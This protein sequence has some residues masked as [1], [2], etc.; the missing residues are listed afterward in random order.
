MNMNRYI[1][2]LTFAFFGAMALFACDDK[3]SAVVPTAPAE[4]VYTNS[5]EYG[6]ESFDV[7]SVVRYETE[8]T[9][10]LWLSPVQ[11]LKT[12]G[13][14]MEKGN[15]GVISANRTYLGGRDL[16]K[17]AGSYAGFNDFRFDN[18]YN[19]KAFID[20][21]FKD[22]E[23]SLNFKVEKLF[24][25]AGVSDKFFSGNY[26][27]E[28]IDHEQILKNQW[29]FNRIVKDIK[30]AKLFVKTDSEYNTTTKFT[31]YDDDETVHEAVSVTIPEAKLDEEI[32]DIADILALTYDSGKAFELVNS[33][34]INKMLATLSDDNLEID[35][36]FANGSNFLAA[37]YTGK[38]EISE[39]KPNHISCAIYEKNENGEFEFLTIRRTPIHKLF[40][41]A[42]YS[43]TSFYFGMSEDAS[44]QYNH[45]Y[46]TLFVGTELIDG[47]YRFG[48]SA[49]GRFK[50]SDDFNTI[51]E[52]PFGGDEIPQ[53]TMNIM[54][55]SQNT[56]KIILRLD[57]LIISNVKMAQVEV[58]YEGTGLFN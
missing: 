1:K 28:F 18:G 19:G 12:I 5:Y 15:Y 51:S 8:T 34:N 50:Y 57:N 24:S 46:P 32:N 33:A 29:S 48:A 3:P 31:F 17:K 52:Q 35:M 41:K 37:D 36:D 58:F 20:M 54:Q 40:V 43:S 4:M 44:S 7:Q 21:S 10:E 14:V 23:V 13:E 45:L 11:N 56:Y 55:T 27:G 22:N 53:G 38:V 49:L 2:Y 26:Q 39:S 9:V 6:D 30:S 47:K 25:D 42:G 16:F